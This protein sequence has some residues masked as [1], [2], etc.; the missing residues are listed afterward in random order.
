MKQSNEMSSVQKLRTLKTNGF[1]VL[2]KHFLK[3]LLSDN[4]KTIVQ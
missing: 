4:I 2:N 1:Y 3:I